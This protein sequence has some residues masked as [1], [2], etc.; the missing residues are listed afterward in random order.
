MK[1]KKIEIKKWNIVK[2][3]MKEVK[4]KFTEKVRENVQ[5]TQLEAVEDIN[6]KRNKIKKKE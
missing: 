5:N 6:E 3:N 4:E 1:T 2:L